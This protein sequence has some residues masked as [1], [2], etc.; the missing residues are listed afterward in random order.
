M[1]CSQLQSIMVGIAWQQKLEETGH[2]APIARKQRDECCSWLASLH[3]AQG[4][5]IWDP[6]Q[7]LS[8]QLIQSRNFHPPEE[9]ILNPVRPTININHHT[10]AH[11]LPPSLTSQGTFS[12]ELA[13]GSVQ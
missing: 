4:P 13:G 12:S 5:S 1:F 10:T 2:I 9:V 3:S 7:V 11:C 6:G 8:P